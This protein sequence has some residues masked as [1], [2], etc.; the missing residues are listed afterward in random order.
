MEASNFIENIIINDL[1]SGKRENII[2]RFPPEP[3]GYLHIGHAKSLCIN[4]G[5]K[6]KFNGKCNLRFDDTNPTKEDVEYVESIKKDIKWLGFEWDQELYA[7]DYFEKMYEYAVLLIKKGL[8]Y[9]CDLNA[10]QIRETRGTLT[11]AGKE[12][13]YRN[14]TIEENLVLFREMR[15][16]KYADGE[17]VLRAKID[18]ASSNINMRDPVMYRILRAHHH[19]TANDWLIYPM[20]DFAHPIED[21]IE[22]ITHSICTLEFEDHRPLYDW[23][24][25]NCDFIKPPQQIEF[26]RLN[27]KNTIMSKRYLK[28]LVD[29]GIVDGWSDP[30]MPTLT[31]MRRRGYPP[32]AIKNFCSRVGVAKANSEVDGKLLEYCVREHLNINAPRAMMVEKPLKI[33][34]DNWQQGLYEDISIADNPNQENSSKHTVRFGKEI[35]IDSRDFSLNPPPKYYRLVKGGMIR[36]KCAYILKYS[37]VDLGQNGEVLAVHCDYIEKS[38]SGEENSGIKVKA[39][40]QWINCQ[41][42]VKCKLYKYSSLLTDEKE[43]MKN[44]DQRINPQSLE[45][46]E[47][48]LVEPF[49]ADGKAGESYQFIR[50]AYYKLAEKQ[51]DLLVFY[52]IVELKDSFKVILP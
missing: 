35:Y 46:T 43:G 18:M 28:K 38:K 9:V 36:L 6:E 16:G 37:S 11:E 12:S 3:N 32:E 4:F 44:F 17:K 30:R 5:I 26:A 41:D 7:S 14:R 31:G 10:D 13:P 20:Y 22:G 15:E 50:E 42:A 2:T 45:I 49:L 21:A 25:N 34:V 19:R 39:T 48:A 24:V 40:V 51:N 29:E 27:I 33:I 8:A 1:D 47:T 52:R 23:F